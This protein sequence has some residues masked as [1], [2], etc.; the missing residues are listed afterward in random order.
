ML[1]FLF[2]RDIA[3]TRSDLPFGYSPD[4][5]SIQDTIIIPNWL[6]IGP[7]S[8]GA[9]EPG[10]SYLPDIENITPYEGLKQR[11]IL[12]Q[13]GELTWRLVKSKDGK[14]KVKGDSVNQEFIQDIYGSIGLLGV[15]YAFG[16]FDNQGEKRA[17][18]IAE[19]CN[20]KL[21]GKGFI[22]D[23]YGAGYVQI[24]VMLKDGENQVLVSVSGFGEREFTFKI[25][26]APNPVLAIYKDVTAPDIIYDQGHNS[27]IGIPIL[28]TLP[29]AIDEAKVIIG[30]NKLIQFTETNAGRIAP[31]CSKKVPVPL[32]VISPI[33]ESIPGD[34][35]L[36]PV[37]VNYQD[38]LDSGYIKLRLR[39]SN[40]SR[41][42]SFI[43]KIDGSVQYYAVLPPIDEGRRTKDER[44]NYA[45][46]LTLHGASVEAIR[47]V[48][49]YSAKDWAYV[50]APT[51]RRPFGFDW[52][53]W[54]RLDALE[55]LK[56]ITDLLHA[57]DENRIYLAGHSMGGHGTWHI[58][59][60]HSDLFAAI[61]PSAGWSSFQIYVPWSL[62]KSL[63][64]G[65]PDQLAIRD[66]VLREDNPLAFLENTRNLP[67]YILQGGE[68]D[69]VPS[70]H[71]RLFAKYL[72]AESLRDSSALPQAVIYKEVPEMGHWWDN[73]TLPG[74][75][76]V[77][78]PEMM[79]FLKNHTRNPYPK[80]IHF[81]TTDLS[82][83]NQHY[84]ITIDQLDKLYEDA[85]IDAK[86]EDN[87]III[88]S[89][90]I[91]QFTLDLN[92]NIISPLLFPPPSGGG[93]KVGGKIRFV[94]NNQVLVHSIQ[95]MPYTISFMQEISC[96]WK[97]ISGVQRQELD[98]KQAS[99]FGPIKQAY[100]SPFVL[101]YGTK[102]DSAM[103]D[104][105]L[106]QARIQALTW[107]I[108]ANGMVEIL[109]DT[110]VTQTM[111]DK[112]N[113]ILFG[114]AQTNFFTAKVQNKL[115]IQIFNEQVQLNISSVKRKAL[116]V[117]RLFGDLGIVFIY[118]NPLN[119]KKF[120]LIHEG[121]NEKGQKLSDRFGAIYSGAGL[122]DFL[123]LSDEVKQKSWAGIKA[124]GFFSNQWQL[125]SDLMYLGKE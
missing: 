55:S 103:T 44:G 106:H 35:I 7:F 22:G 61:A 77:D 8:S 91:N 18:V 125:E 47:Q 9:R 70:I 69:N 67:I 99:S 73:D 117:K 56:H 89:H 52:Q 59:L 20:F 33:K 36:V 39:K 58:G 32:K 26:P 50:V 112:Y 13:D 113:L 62:Q 43:S 66:K 2:V 68:D 31:L 14:L 38:Y 37:K 109:P 60:A 74:T 97:I 116:R 81:K 107:W 65:Q 53:D 49:S 21:N 17:L 102:G 122:P 28:N 124:G 115:P 57:V 5:P 4:I 104:L 25:I 82:Q 41:K 10:I 123:I 101:V 34:T 19:R 16:K 48:D 64:F 114:N 94:I 92:E 119:P 42:E 30:D 40:Q 120:I 88:Q 98:V 46:I 54:G 121:T 96:K 45:L 1:C 24:P 100:F 85:I 63:F 6:T 86:V 110:E 87:T 29:N 12:T 95:P 75:A 78:Y 3:A 15:S 105:L 51:N 23:P 71:A 90:N 108:R 80:Q 118:P 79:A 111:I 93:G 11:D 83:N 72:E 84:W 27:W 76:C